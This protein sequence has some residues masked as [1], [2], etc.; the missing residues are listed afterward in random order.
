[1][2]LRTLHI[3]GS[4]RKTGFRRTEWKPSK[5]AP[6]GKADD[7]RSESL[8]NRQKV[9]HFPSY[10]FFFIYIHLYTWKYSAEM[11]MKKQ[12]AGQNVLVL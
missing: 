11:G 7:K 3:F 8:S 4:Q 1:M 2:E 10:M 5:A 6:I 9:L 12:I